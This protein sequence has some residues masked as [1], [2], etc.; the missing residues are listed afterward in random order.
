M[1]WMLD[2]EDDVP[3]WRPSR[4]LPGALVAMTSRRGGVS[5]APFD[6]LNLGKSTAD[7]PEAV[8]EN[9]ARVLT[10]LGVEPGRLATAGQVHGT[11]VTKVTSP[12][13]HPDTDGLVTS[14]PHLALAV[15][16][17][18]C[19]SIAVVADGAV[20]AAHSGWRG[21]AGG[22]PVAALESVCTESGARPDRV[23]VLFGPCIGPCCY[24]VGE[25]VAA[26]FPAE[27]VT[28]GPDGPHVDLARAATRQLLDA[29]VRIDAILP[30]PVCT[31]CAAELCFSHRRE[32]GRTGRLWGVVVLTA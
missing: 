15:T 11:R 14:V 17:A 18:D 29:G 20:A 23:H 24:V 22:M 2:L 3:L 10:R 32:A 5:A 26:R 12:G 7:A 9:R 6:T 21:T 16:A 8:T 13:L 19:M 27:A 4:P 30:P 31:S 25:D 1:H 28:T